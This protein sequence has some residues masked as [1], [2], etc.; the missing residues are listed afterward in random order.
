MRYPPPSPGGKAKAWRMLAI[1][2]VTVLLIVLICSDGS[3]AYSV[4]THEDIVDLLS[5]DA[6][7]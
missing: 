6:I 5:T 3:S 1:R 7:R 2:V 4:L